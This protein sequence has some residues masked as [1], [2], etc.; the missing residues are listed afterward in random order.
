VNGGL[1]T[2]TSVVIP[3]DQIQVGPFVFRVEVVDGDVATRLERASGVA[4]Q[5]GHDPLTGLV[6]ARGIAPMVRE[7]CSDALGRQV[8]L[9]G[10]GLRARDLDAIHAEF[11]EEAKRAVLQTVARI[12]LLTVPDPERVGVTEDGDIVAMLV[13]VDAIEAKKLTVSICRSVATHPWD[14]VRSGLVVLLQGQSFEY[15]A[16]ESL[17]TW[18]EKLIGSPGQR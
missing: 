1:I 13:G 6:S 5:A 9:S 17:S 12:V 3:G 14:R 18:V 10:I 2:G 8:P 15:R 11:G 16:P 7:A 4:T